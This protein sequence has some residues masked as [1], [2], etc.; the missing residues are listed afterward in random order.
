MVVHRDASA[1]K[2]AAG[3]VHRAN[4]LRG[5]MRKLIVR[6]DEGKVKDL[7]KPGFASDAELVGERCG[8]LFFEVANF[9]DEPFAEKYGA[10]WPVCCN[11]EALSAATLRKCSRA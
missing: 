9:G 6:A 10:V 11:S 3:H 5:F 7:K 1:E 4:G 8:V 2:L